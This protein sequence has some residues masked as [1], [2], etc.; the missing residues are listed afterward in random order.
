MTV[1]G[2]SVD[3]AGDGGA[4]DHFP[5]GM[6]VLAVDDDPICLKVLEHLLRKC[7]YHVTTTKRSIEAL[8]M[9]RENRNKVDLVISDVNMPDMD[10]FKL[11]ELVGLE[12]DLPVI[13]LS[14]HSDTE[15]VMKGIAHGACD[16][17]LKPVR[18]E[19]LKNIWQHVI[20][21]K[22]LEPKTKN[23][24]PNQDNIGNG[25]SEGEQG[26][27]LTS[28]ADNAKLNRKRKEQDDDED[29]EGKE[30]EVD[31]DDPSNLKR[32]RVVW[33]VELHRKFVSAVNQLGLEKAVPKKI[34]DLM[35]VEGL[36]REN[37]ASHLQKYRLYLKRISNVA[38]QQ[39]NMAATFGSKEGTYMRIG[40]YDGYGDMH[41][42]A[43]SGWLPS[44]SLSYYSPVGMSLIQ[45]SSH[46]L[47]CAISNLGSFQPAIMLPSHQA[48][49]LLQGI[50]TSLE[51]G[52]LQHS[53]STTSIG[54]AFD[55]DFGCS[56]FL[57][58][59]PSNGNWQGAAQLLRFSATLNPN[60]EYPIDQMH[61]MNSSIS[62]APS[63]NRN[64]S[65]VGSVSAPLLDSRDLRCQA[66]VGVVDSMPKQ[67][68]EEHEHE[69]ARSPLSQRFN[70]NSLVCE[71]KVGSSLI[72][73]SN[74]AQ[75]SFPQHSVV[76]KLGP[77]TKMNADRNLHDGSIQGSIESL[78]DI[79]NA[80]IKQ[81]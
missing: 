53:K 62:S 25:G 24:L 78:D 5:V 37:V 67:S 64:I 27:S 42:F 15:L 73:P 77:N 17:L 40:S 14:A 43:G 71:R 52:H 22:K 8:K 81:V 41:G 33:S 66:G 49:N 60:E 50:P 12:M 61:A 48:T 47:N 57:D 10:G 26:F 35:N 4:A 29:E 69:Y 21:R 1:E 74:D 72:V 30:N 70:Q 36:T 9:L 51:L 2:H 63:T 44:S 79:M 7:Q 45:Q 6:R 68:W 75:L 58:P 55:I 65:V 59:D 56:S 38:S 3:S 11:L 32:P 39:A 23:K 76:E 54:E 31:I 80:M 16:Y 19:E 46:N 34:L 20:R 18:I 13:M 28:N